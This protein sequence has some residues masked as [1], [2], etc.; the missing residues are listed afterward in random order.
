MPGEPVGKLPA[1]DGRAGCG[2]SCALFRKVGSVRETRVDYT[3]LRT[4]QSAAYVTA[5][6]DKF[7]TGNTDGITLF[8]T[9]LD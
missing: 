5:L 7:T 4:R 1:L 2:H 8:G 9:L 6:I 3:L